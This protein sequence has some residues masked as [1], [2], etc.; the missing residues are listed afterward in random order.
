MNPNLV[1]GAGSVPLSAKSKVD[2]GA[3]RPENVATGV[4]FDSVGPVR[5]SPIPTE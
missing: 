4:F 3:D 5:V 1:A 2:T